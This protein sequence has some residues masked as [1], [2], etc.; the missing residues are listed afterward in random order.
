MV[1]SEIPDTEGHIVCD[2][3]SVESPQQENPQ[4]KRGLVGPGEGL[5]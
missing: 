2:H 1:L 4:T 5:G 3:I